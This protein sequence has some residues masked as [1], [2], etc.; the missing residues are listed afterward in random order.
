MRK[1]RTV[2]EMTW[3]V[4]ILTQFLKGDCVEAVGHPAAFARDVETIMSRLTAEGESFLTKTLPALGRRI[5]AAL[6]D[7]APLSV[8]AFKKRR[9]GS[10]IPAFLSGLLVRI[11]EDDGRLKNAPCINS[12]RLARQVCYWFY[13][14][15]RGYSERSL[16]K[17]TQKLIATDSNLPDLGTF[18]DRR[19]LALARAL[20]S[21]V[22]RKIDFSD[23]RPKHGPGAVAGGETIVEKRKLRHRYLRLESRF[24]P[25]PIFYGLSEICQNMEQFLTSYQTE[26]GLS[27]VAFVPKDSR[28]PRVI[29]LEPAEYMWCQQ[30]L[31]SVLYDHIEKH[32][33]TAGHVNFADQTVN[34][35]CALSWSTQD[36]LDMSD[37]SDRNSLALVEFLFEKTTLLH[38]LRA[39]R[40]PGTVLPTGEV[41]WF[42]KFAPM[43]SAVCFPV[44]ALVYWALA[45]TALRISGIPLWIALRSVY[46]YGDDLIVPH[47]Y[48]TAINELFE[49]V[50]LKFNIDKCCI[51]GK[52]RES[53]GL[54]AYDGEDITPLRL[55]HSERGQVLSNYVPLVEHA[56]ALYKRGYWAAA[57]ELKKQIMDEC[58]VKLPTF[59]EELPVLGFLGD[60]EENLRRQTVN[61]ITFVQGFVA[62]PRK[63]L[64]EPADERCYL[65]ESLSRVG[66]V[67]TRTLRKRGRKG[68]LVAERWFSVKYASALR[69]EW[70]IDRAPSELTEVQRSI[71][72]CV[73]NQASTSRLFHLESRRSLA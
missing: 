12:I 46:V 43:G 23:L 37:A 7:T 27:R 53:C 19:D 49:S 54:D 45:V 5:D 66:P 31:K 25:M 14:M 9:T 47:G 57:S 28:G 10:A 61:N 13:K 40:T 63:I 20:I 73:E 71:L 22:C 38:W 68:T 36:T 41:L 24:R 64:G 39:A 4:S 16:R 2:L 30:A 15:E 29:S 26:Y 35:K 48:F 59:T 51:S 33:L 1:N 18:S 42:K 6:Q 34:R 62:K 56:N 3:Y 65:R 8:T 58:P 67:G 32:R 55:K 69:K 17:A 21:E 70:V 11:F 72:R 44:Q 50:G 52:F 60:E